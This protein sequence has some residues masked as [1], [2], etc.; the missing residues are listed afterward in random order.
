MLNNESNI[1]SAESSKSSAKLFNYG[2]I[3]SVLIPPIFIF[4]FGASMVFYAMQRHHP[5]QRVGHY[6][7]IAAYQYYTLAGLLVPVL[8]FVPGNFLI[9]YWIII[10][11]LCVVIMISLAIIQLIK[12]NSEEWEDVK[13]DKK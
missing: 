13:I 6:T 3:L 11:T 5:N 8:T 4:W 9:K 12:I 10:W 1:V 7:Q 2:N